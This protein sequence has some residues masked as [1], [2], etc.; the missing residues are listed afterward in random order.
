MSQ[1]RLF[2]SSCEAVV[3]Q[4]RAALVYFKQSNKVGQDK[5]LWLFST[6]AVTHQF[7]GSFSDKQ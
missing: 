3:S 4:M 7:P 1:N 5:N 2:I 6:I